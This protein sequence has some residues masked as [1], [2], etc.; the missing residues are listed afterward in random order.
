[1]DGKTLVRRNDKAVLW[2]L[3][4]GKA[5]A[6]LTEKGEHLG[7]CRF[8]P[9]GKV[10]AGVLYGGEAIRIVLW[11]AA[12]GKRLKQL[13]AGAAS[14][15]ALALSPEGALLAVGQGVRGQTV[16]PCDVEVWDVKAGRKA[17]TLRGHVNDVITVDFH[18]DG[19]LLATG[20]SDGTVRLW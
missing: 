20:G 15:R 10:I 18:P 4:S 14:V 11:D 12:S 8:S 7:Q 3:A 17:L 6:S 9:D 13:P 5:Q 19:K 1:P 2:D 16:E